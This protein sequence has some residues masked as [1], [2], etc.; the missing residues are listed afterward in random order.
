MRFMY[1]SKIIQFKGG[2]LAAEACA[3]ATTALEQ[4]VRP[5]RSFLMS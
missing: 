5:E 1:C 3:D 4:R 2:T